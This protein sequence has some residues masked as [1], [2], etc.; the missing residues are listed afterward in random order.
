T[1]RRTVAR[2]RRSGTGR[3]ACRHA[4]AAP[5]A[6]SPQGYGPV[7]WCSFRASGRSRSP[8]G[9]SRLVLADH[10]APWHVAVVR[11]A[12]VGLDHGVVLDDRPLPHIRGVPGLDPVPD[13]CIVADN[14]TVQTGEVPDGGTAS[15]L[16]V[17][18]GDHLR[19]D[20]G[21]GADD[22]S[23]SQSRARL[24]P[25]A[26]QHFAV[27]IELGGEVLRV[28]TGGAFELRG[29]ADL[30]AVADT[31]CTVQAGTG[32]DSDAVAQHAGVLPP[33]RDRRILAH[34]Q[35]P[36]HARVAERGLVCQLGAVSEA[37]S[38]ID[39]HRHPVSDLDIMAPC[40]S[41]EQPAAGSDLQLVAEG[42]L[43]S[44]A[45]SDAG[46]VADDRVGLELCGLPDGGLL[47]DT[48]GVADLCT[49]LDLAGLSDRGTLIDRHP[50]TDAGVR[51]DLYV[52][53]DPRLGADGD[54]L[55][56]N[57]SIAE[58][59]S[60]LDGRVVADRDAVPHGDGFD[61]PRPVLDP[62]A[63]ADHGPVPD[64]DALTER[65]VRSDGHVRADG[66]IITEAGALV[67]SGAG[68]DLDVL[69]ELRAG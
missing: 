32:P 18:P 68:V 15:D 42:A 30:H 3:T 61:Q 8:A 51:L 39:L 55:T 64:H 22:R 1:G 34:R 14:R 25:R 24:D 35:L 28:A 66:G 50:R 45:R 54:L 58:D 47:P 52:A 49:V 63:I 10:G 21:A 37:G 65:D 20:L 7:S 62:R 19:A 12:G 31:D 48:H 38:L 9:R 23:L 33:A 4:G 13:A 29:L 26:V 6:A 5:T 17:R 16:G 69:T 59:G 36:A 56:E 67:D 40:G 41:A 11:D 2:R 46:A 60:R 27:G 57:G 53:A 43:Q 44:A